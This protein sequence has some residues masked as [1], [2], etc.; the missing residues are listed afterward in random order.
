M[1]APIPEPP[2]R[3]RW[4]RILLWTAVIV[5]VSPFLVFGT[6]LLLFRVH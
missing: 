1:N 5:I 2:R 6:C 4:L 3:P